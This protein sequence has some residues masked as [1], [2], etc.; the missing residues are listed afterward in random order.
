[1]DFLSDTQW[2]ALIC[3]QPLVGQVSEIACTIQQACANRIVMLLM[4]LK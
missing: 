1:M 4:T 3:K 2:E